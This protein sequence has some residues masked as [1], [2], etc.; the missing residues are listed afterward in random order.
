M[1]TINIFTV[2]PA[3]CTIM[4][5]TVLSTIISFQNQ[6]LARKLM[7]NPFALVHQKIYYQVVTSGFIHADWLHLLFNMITFYF[8]A[9]SIEGI[10]PLEYLMT[11]WA[12][13]IGHLYFV[14]IYMGSMILG[15]FSTIIRHKDNPSYYSLGASGAISGV[16]FSYVLFSPT[17]R[18]SM[19]FLPSMP[20]PVFAF[21]YVIFSILAARGRNTNIN[22]EAHL[23]GGLFGFALTI[24]LFP[25]IFPHFLEEVKHLLHFF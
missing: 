14:L 10:V 6:V 9:I 3:A 16:I 1:N 20:A 4:A 12:G 24:A 22:H 18:L 2:S 15:D 25:G 11:S 8:F 13:P 7:L 5:I 19:F 23:W 21:V 17:S